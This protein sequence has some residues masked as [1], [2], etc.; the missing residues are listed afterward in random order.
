MAKI[1]TIG[2]REELIR[3]KELEKDEST[4]LS[5]DTVSFDA[6]FSQHFSSLSKDV[7]EGLKVLADIIYNTGWEKRKKEK[8]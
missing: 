5:M 3:E 8:S 4:F 7:Q 6:W 2:N 1:R